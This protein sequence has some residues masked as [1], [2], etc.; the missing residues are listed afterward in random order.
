MRRDNMVDRNTCIFK[1]L[2][3]CILLVFCKLQLNNSFIN[4]K[5][6]Y[7]KFD[8]LTDNGVKIQSK[9]KKLF[10]NKISNT[11]STKHRLITLTILLVEFNSFMLV[12]HY[13]FL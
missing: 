12:F 11:R 13:L 8:V 2:F 9:S 3:I 7:Q 4:N 10:I 6:F 1:S 5:K